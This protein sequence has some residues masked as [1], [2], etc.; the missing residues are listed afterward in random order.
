MGTPLPP[1]VGKQDVRKS[2]TSPSR[3]RTTS[4]LSHGSSVAET[5]SLALRA[6]KF[7]L[8]LRS[9]RLQDWFLEP[10]QHMGSGMGKLALEGLWAAAARPGCEKGPVG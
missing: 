7:L 8:S 1:L 6:L 10:G 4:K 5:S 9:A 3:A 2:Y